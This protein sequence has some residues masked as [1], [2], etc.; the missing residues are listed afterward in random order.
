MSG[1]TCRKILIVDDE[2]DLVKLLT[3][4]LRD[5]GRYEVAVAYDGADGLVQAVQFRPDIALIDLALPDLDGWQLCRRLRENT[6]TRRIKVIIMT[7]WLSPDLERHALSEGVTK[8][9]LKPFEETE[10]FKALDGDFAPCRPTQE[11]L[12]REYPAIDEEHRA[13][14]SRP[15]AHRDH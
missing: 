12:R 8:I 11:G 9:L 4:R 13:P 5:A 1:Q 6:R 3:M 14:V 15:A 10:L 7:A 2:C